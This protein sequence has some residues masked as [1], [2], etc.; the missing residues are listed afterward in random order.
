MIHKNSN[1][2]KKVTTRQSEIITPNN[3][4][5]GDKIKA[6]DVKQNKYVDVTVLSILKV[7]VPRVVLKM[8][9]GDILVISSESMMASSGIVWCS[10]DLRPHSEFKLLKKDLTIHGPN[11]FTPVIKSK[12]LEHNDIFYD[13]RID[14]DCAVLVDGYLQYFKNANTGKFGY[15]AG[16]ETKIYGNKY[17]S[18]S[19]DAEQRTLRMPEESED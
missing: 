12:S 17:T 3:L 8:I 4:V 14:G 5:E 11:T 19:L 7:S 10:K 16:F 15:E 13:I 2:V 9:N 18:E 1:I 6:W